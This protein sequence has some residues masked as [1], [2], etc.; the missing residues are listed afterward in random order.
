MVPYALLT[1]MAF[2]KAHRRVRQIMR[3][4][5][6]VMRNGFPPAFAG[7]NPPMVRF[8]I[9]VYNNLQNLC[10]DFMWQHTW[11]SSEAMESSLQEIEEEY[12]EFGSVSARMRLANDSFMNQRGFRPS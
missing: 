2:R 9:S 8:A 10:M 11:D 6:S 5:E 3:E 1:D 4:S 12:A 7:V